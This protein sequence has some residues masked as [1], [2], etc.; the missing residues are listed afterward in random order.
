LDG[1]DARKEESSRILSACK[2]G[3]YVLLLDETGAALGSPDIA[4]HIGRAQYSSQDICIVIGGAYG[5]DQSVKDRAQCVISFG[6]AVFPHQLMRVMVLEQLY[7]AYSILA[8]G[9][10]HHE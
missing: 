10:Y 1:N 3:E 7:R 4:S 5:V 2:A 6:K 9:K 8:G